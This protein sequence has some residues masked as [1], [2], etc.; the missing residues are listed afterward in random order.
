[1]LKVKSKRDERKARY[2]RYFATPGV[3]DELKAKAEPSND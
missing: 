1:L 2:A 3:L